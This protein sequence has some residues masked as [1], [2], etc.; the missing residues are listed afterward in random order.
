M[1]E[2]NPMQRKFVE[3]FVI[4][5]HG[6]KSAIA[7]GYSERSASAQSSA[8]LKNPKILEYLKEIETQAFL[9]AGVT[10]SRIVKELAKVAFDGSEGEYVKAG[11]KL[12]ALETLAKNFNLADDTINHRGEI[13]TI[14]IKYE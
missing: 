10:A 14:S 5:G 1:Q 8:L 2:L 12:R 11:D 4:T 6:T 3:E 13:K 9:M 7:A